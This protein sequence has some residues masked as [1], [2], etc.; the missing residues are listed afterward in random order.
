MNS[1]IKDRES[2]RRCDPRLADILEATF[3]AENRWRFIDDCPGKLVP[4]PKKNCKQQ[5]GGGSSLFWPPAIFLFYSSPPLESCSW[6][7][8]CPLHSRPQELITQCI[9]QSTA[10]QFHSFLSAQLH[11][12]NN[13]AQLRSTPN[14]P[15]NEYDSYIAY[16]IT[17][18]FILLCN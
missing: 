9:T 2:L 13:W 12:G 7:H 4:H 10:Q 3:G 18:R 14:P 15:S 11:R 5:D 16:H 8:P 1:G 17:S 6:I